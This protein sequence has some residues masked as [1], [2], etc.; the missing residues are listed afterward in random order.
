MVIPFIRQFIDAVKLRG[1]ERGRGRILHDDFFAVPLNHGFPAHGVVLVL[2]GAAGTRVGEIAL[3]RFGFDYLERGTFHGIGNIDI[4]IC[5]NGVGCAADIVHHAD[6][7][8]VC[9]AVGDFRYLMLSHTEHE[10]VRAGIDENGGTHRVVPVVVMGKAPQRG[11]KAADAERNIAEKPANRFAVDRDG[12][13]GTASRLAAGGVIVVVTFAFC[14]G[15]VRHHGVDIAAVHEKREPRPSEALVIVVILR[16]RQD[17]DT[18]TLRFQYARDNRR[19]EARVIDVGVARDDDDIRRV[20]A[21]RSHLFF[22][23]RQ[24]GHGNTP[25]PV[26]SYAYNRRQNRLYL[27]EKASFSF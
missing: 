4:F 8:P 2:L 26:K 22:C 6:G 24:K 3:R 7:L 12:A 15:I 17:T 14:G 9:K 5:R 20:P 27:P 25:F 18:E 16:L 19:A 11:F 1:F 23:N 21:A 10:K 13:V